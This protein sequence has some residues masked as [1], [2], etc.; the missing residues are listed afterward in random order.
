MR[1]APR[2]HA[3]ELLARLKA[4]LETHLLA[5]EEKVAAELGQGAS[6]WAPSPLLE[7]WRLRARE[8]GLWNLSLPAPWGP[9]LTHLEYAP[10]AELMGANE[11]IP[12]VFNS[13]PPDSG[14]ISA[15]AAFGGDAQR[16][17]WLKPLL[18]GEI[19]SCF[20][21]TEPQVASSD[22][23][24]IALMAEETGGEWL[25]NGEKW[26]ISGAGHPLCKIALVVCCSDPAAERK[27]R[28]SVLLVPLDTPGVS[29]TRQLSVFGYDFA[30]RG[31]SQ[32]KFENVRVSAGNLLGQRGEGLAVAQSR[33]GGGRLHHAMRC[34]G[35]A[36]RAL[37]LM[38]ARSVKRQAFGKNLADLGATAELIAECRI[39]I[40]MA[41]ELVLTAAHALDSQGPERARSL[42]S[43]I[44]VAAPRM[45]C[46]VVDRAMQLHGAAGF[47]EDTPLAALYARLRTIR[48]AD[49]PD[50][51][52]LRVIARD[53]L[54]RY[55][56]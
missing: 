2:P 53:E 25:L 36:E 17:A 5:N 33:L 11:W 28:H 34:I 55:R 51:V 14:N 13:N 50:A 10:F 22:A 31:F 47:S 23:S 46:A 49:G 1:P 27:R 4:F 24:N 43:Q 52:H 54:A 40:N 12:E 48:I 20:A 45:A 29:V 41:R 8:E 38:C 37:A 6:R 56:S 16:E 18:R 7:A 26:W 42:I 9:G 19:R 3:V 44:K 30:P 15:L 32:L 35:A 39:E 21:M